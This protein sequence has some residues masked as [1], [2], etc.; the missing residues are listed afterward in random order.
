MLF[1]LLSGCGLD[2][3]A[4]VP[5]VRF[6]R[7]DVSDIDFEHIDTA[8]VFAVDNPNPVGA[9]VDRFSYA[10]ALAGVELLSGDDPN[11]LELK[12][13]DTSEVALPVS[14]VFAS[15]YDAVNG[16]RGDDS[17]LAPSI[18]PVWRVGRVPE[19]RPRSVAGWRR[20][21][22]ISSARGV[23]RRSAP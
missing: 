4:F 8:F 16:A 13:A 11:G 12:A 23:T 22:Q 6:D 17:Y 10:L 21:C 15:I 1:L 3:S 18:R 19:G 5:T 2:L 9:P 14:L 20:A 7:M